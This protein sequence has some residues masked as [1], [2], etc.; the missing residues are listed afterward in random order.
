MTISF[1]RSIYLEVSR[2]AVKDAMDW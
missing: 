2:K 1:A